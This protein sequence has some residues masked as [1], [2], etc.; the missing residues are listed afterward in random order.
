MTKSFGTKAWLLLQ[1]YDQTDYTF[2]L[3]K[4]YPNQIFDDYFCNRTVSQH[5]QGYTNLFQPKTSRIQCM[6]PIN[7]FNKPIYWH[8]LIQQFWILGKRQ[9]TACRQVTAVGLQFH[10]I[11]MRHCKEIKNLWYNSISHQRFLIYII[12]DKIHR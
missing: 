9:W 2:N 3:G 6:L 5:K 1:I 12:R 7:N 11:M 8:Q 10:I 4:L